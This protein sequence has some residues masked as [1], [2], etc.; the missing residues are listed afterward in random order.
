MTH[1]LRSMI[2]RPALALVTPVV[3]LAGTPLMPPSWS[4]AAGVERGSGLVAQTPAAAVADT[5]TVRVSASAS[6]SV[7]ADRARLTFAVENQAADANAAA[8]AN[9]AQMTR[10]LAAVREAAG[11]GQVVETRGYSL[12]PVYEQIRENNRSRSEIVGFMATNT[13]V[14]TL[15]DLDAVGPTLDAAVAA[16]ANRIDGIQFFAANTRQPYL[17]ALDMA[18]QNALQEAR[19]MA[20]AAGGTLGEVIEVFSTS[21]QSTPQFARMAMDSQE[22][23][24]P[25]EPGSQMVSASVTLLVRLRS[26]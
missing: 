10:A 2:L 25:V 4:A 21:G 17:R 13:L 8:Q 15:S 9:A 6:I 23:A 3:L 14:V 20:N 19:V 1:S 7:E 12:R 18:V 24:T 26:R 16:G 5:G 22:F 11:E